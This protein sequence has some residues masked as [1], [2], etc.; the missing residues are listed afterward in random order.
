MKKLRG[1]LKISGDKS[2]SHRALILSSMTSGRAVIRNL[3]ESEDI[4]STIK[5]LKLLGIK[6]FKKSNAW[7]VIGNGTNGFMQPNRDLNCGNSGTTARLII[8]AVSSNPISCNFFGDYSLSKRSM[9]RVTVYLE[10]LGATFKLH[11]GKYLPLKV[12]GSTSLIPSLIK[13]KKPS[14]QIKSA[15]MLSGLNVNGKLSIIEKARTRDHTERLF[16]Y[17]NIK[18]KQKNL[19]NG[20]KLIELNGPYEIRSKDIKVASDP[21]SAAF[22]IVGALITPGSKIQLNNIALNPTRIEYINV[23]K[24]MGAIISIKKTGTICGEEIGN[25][26]AEYSQLNGIKINKSLAPLLID[27]YPILSIAASRAKGKTH[28]Y[29]LDELRKKESDRIK[30]IIINLNKVGIKATNVKDKISIHGGGRLPQKNIRIQTFGDH[31]IAMAFLILNIICNANLKLDNDKCIS[32]S[33]PNFKK[34]LKKLIK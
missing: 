7:I 5:V 13:I 34:D 22:F 15:L 10:T 9:S 31:R 20:S 28:M 6:I 25:I 2:I 32:I 21:S 19:K 8:G 3:L 26:K 30:S 24:K 29:G 4:K 16:K 1:V 27:E 14:A 12:K 23:L 11:R 17:L 18:F 33:Y